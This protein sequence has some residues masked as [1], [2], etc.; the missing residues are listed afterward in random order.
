M[1]TTKEQEDEKGLYQFVK[2]YAK[3]VEQVY[4]QT[5]NIKDKI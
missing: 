2:K 3:I 5:L 4:L 1:S